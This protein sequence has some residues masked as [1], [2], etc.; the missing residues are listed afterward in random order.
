MLAS[1][2]LVGVRD[3][4]AIT[5]R[6]GDFN[7]YSLDISEIGASVAC[8]AGCV[9][10]TSENLYT[11]CSLFTTPVRSVQPSKIVSPGSISANVAVRL[12]SLQL[13]V[14]M[15]SV[16]STGCFGRIWRGISG[17]F[18]LS[19]IS[20]GLFSAVDGCRLRMS[21]FSRS[22]H[23]T[24]PPPLSGNVVLSSPAFVVN[25]RCRPFN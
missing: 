5:E 17:S 2:T 20:C 8:M 11:V 3:E 1:R 13:F 6:N 15:A 19:I 7:P 23:P 22:P 12:C 4:K 9:S 25:M 16:V 18:L 24:D 10:C 21:F 14:A